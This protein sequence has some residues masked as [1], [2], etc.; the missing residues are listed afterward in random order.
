MSQTRAEHQIRME[1]IIKDLRDDLKT[2]IASHN[3]TTQRLRECQLELMKRKRVNSEL[4]DKLNRIAEVLSK[5]DDSDAE[6]S[7]LGNFT[8]SFPMTKSGR[9]ARSADFIVH[10][11][12][13]FVGT[14]CQGNPVRVHASEEP[15][16]PLGV[17][18]KDGLYLKQCSDLRINSDMS[19]GDLLAIVNHMEFK[20]REKYVE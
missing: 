13:D 1:D 8:K 11:S 10:S 20:Q 7:Q 3:Q 4:Q 6:Q 18:Y 12:N 2:I 5:L 16:L 14:D 19:P 15:S 9:S 17:I